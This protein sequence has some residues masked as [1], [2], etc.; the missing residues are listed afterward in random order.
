MEFKIVMFFE[1]TIN[2]DWQ[3]PVSI[4]AIFNFACREKLKTKAN[5]KRAGF[6]F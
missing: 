5:T 4:M 1:F 3:K 6:S 2:F